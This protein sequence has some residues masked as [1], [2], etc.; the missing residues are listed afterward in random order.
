MN[1]K[2]ILGTVQFGLNYGINNNTGQISKNEV[3][4]ILDLCSVFKINTLDTAAAYGNSEERIG[5]Y[6]QL[7]NTNHKFRI[8]TKFSLNNGLSLIQSLNHSLKRLKL[9]Q[10][11]TIMFHNIDD[12]KRTSLS[13]LKK[14]LDFKGEKY[15]NLGISLYDNEQ[16]D[17][18]C[19]L[20]LFNIIQLPFNVLDNHNLRGELLHK[21]N[22]KGIETHTRSVFLQGLF[23][24]EIS[25]IPNKLTPL[26]KHLT[27]LNEIANDFKISKEAIA[28]HYAINKS[29]ISGVLMG[30]DTLNH[31]KTNLST[32]SINVPQEV[33]KAIDN[34]NVE[35]IELLNPTT[36]NS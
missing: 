33:F 20:G 11:D 23:F 8:I 24:M 6:L 5:N 27:A 25:N 35:P 26:K 15:L 36:W 2:I 17:E 30:V 22:R 14:L 4:D 13:E 12:F 32:L 9:S 7:K 18:V 21:L 19:E 31:L 34:I 16:I 10:L 29:Y 28:L 1:N 3:Y